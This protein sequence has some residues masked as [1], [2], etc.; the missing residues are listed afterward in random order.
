[1]IDPP[2][3]PSRPTQLCYE[4]ILATIMKANIKLFPKY[5]CTSLCLILGSQN[6][7]EVV[8]KKTVALLGPGV[9]AYEKSI[10]LN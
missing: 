7:F 5:V 3:S 9:R 8:I 1:M 4:I 6:V 10:R 2:V